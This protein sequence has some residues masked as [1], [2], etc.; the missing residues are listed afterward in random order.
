[1]KTIRKQYRVPAKR[2]MQI[3]F[4]GRPCT[5]TGAMTAEQYLRVRVEGD[6]RTYPI[7]PTGEVEYPEVSKETSSSSSVS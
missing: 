6:P 3:L 5:I 7:H 2:G 1:M 4:R